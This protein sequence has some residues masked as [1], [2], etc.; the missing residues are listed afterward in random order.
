MNPASPISD[1]PC[2][3]T[4]PP[5]PIYPNYKNKEPV[6]EENLEDTEKDEQKVEENSDTSS[7]ESS[8]DSSDEE[9]IEITKTRPEKLKEAINTFEETKKKRER[10]EKA[11]EKRKKKKLETREFSIPKAVFKRVIKEIIRDV[12]FENNDRNSIRITKEAL[13]CLRT[14]SES[15]LVDVFKTSAALAEYAGQKTIDDKTMKFATNIESRGIRNP[16]DEENS[17]IKKVA[18]EEEEE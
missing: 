3:F 16:R 7:S 5:S 9:V 17:R 10:A 15:Y 2:A 18:D 14:A 13:T 6:V 4:N 1:L 12:A 8:T 11:K